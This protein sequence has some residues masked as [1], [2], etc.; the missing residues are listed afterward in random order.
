MKILWLNPINASKNSLSVSQGNFMAYEKNEIARSIKGIGNVIVS[1]VCFN[2][3]RIKMSGFSNVTY[4][5]ILKPK[6]VFKIFYH[7]KMLKSFVNQN[8]DVVL[9]GVHTSH[10]IPIVKLISLFRTHKS[11][12]VYDIRSVPVDLDKGLKSK[13]EI[14][15]YNTSLK[16]ADRLCNG[17]TC[18]TPMLGDTL[19][20]KLVKLKDKIGYFQTG[21]NFRI[22]DPSESSSL[23]ESL[24]LKTRFIVI[25]H[26]VLSPNRGLQNVMKA[27]AICKRDIP[28]ILFMVVGTGS[29]KSELKNIA[30]ELRL[31][32]N[33]LFTGAVPFKKVPDYIKT[34]DV[35]VI[36]LPAIDWWNVSS[37]IK[38]KEYLAMQL[39]VIATDIPAH[40][41]VVNKTGGATLIK[42]HEPQSIAQAISS[43]HKTPKPIYPMK[44]RKE[45]YDLISFNSQAISFID[46]VGK[47]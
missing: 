30:K 5:K 2:K 39:P 13:F 29:G 6:W 19:K 24:K 47:L 44:S 40:R 4:F 42:N 36:P 17:I 27:I 7:F 31:E 22:F 38:L 15:R 18:I 10:L 32:K 37:P 23:R 45:L 11:I 34:A 14:F 46:Y 20:P 8:F 43:F 3:N 9:F 1:V 16:I 41:L 26:G 25:Y 28:H 12:L 33:V 21:V 35:G